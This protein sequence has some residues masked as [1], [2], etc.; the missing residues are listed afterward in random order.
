MSSI[1]IQSAETNLSNK[2]LRSIQSNISVSEMDE[3]HQ[4][5]Y[6]QSANY[7]DEND[8]EQRESLRRSL[9]QNPIM[10]NDFCHF[11][12][13]TRVRSAQQPFQQPYN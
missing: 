13:F 2:Q 4:H 12:E 3:A 10:L 8:M 9:A 6:C 5:Q 7:Y 11:L 1:Q